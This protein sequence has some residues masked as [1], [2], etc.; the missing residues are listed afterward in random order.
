MRGLSQWDTR[1]KPTPTYRFQYNGR[2][3]RTKREREEYRGYRLAAVSARSA[4]LEVDDRTL[5]RWAELRREDD[6]IV[7][8]LQRERQLRSEL[9]KKY[10]IQS[11][12]IPYQHLE[13]L[14]QMRSRRRA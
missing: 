13:E 1:R 11:P 6:E 4:G 14:D 10:K 8:S 5:M 2:Y 9:R 7:A 3:F 12:S